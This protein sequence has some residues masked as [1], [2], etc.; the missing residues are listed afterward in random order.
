M[1][2]DEFTGTLDDVVD[3]FVEGKTV[4]GS[5]WDHLNEYENVENVHIVHYEDL[6]EV[7]LIVEILKIFL[8]W[9]FFVSQ[10]FKCYVYFLAIF[11]T[12]CSCHISF[13]N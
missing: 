9:F 4:F 7:F 1:K 13:L 2:E 12:K 5:F 11:K 10:K 3:L 8:T 6:I